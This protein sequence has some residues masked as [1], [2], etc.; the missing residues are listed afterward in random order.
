MRENESREV[1][2]LLDMISL[3]TVPNNF[4]MEQMF[5]H[6]SY[7]S[8]SKKKYKKINQKKTMKQLVA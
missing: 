5:P 4:I 7:R 2:F 1:S 6:D 3:N 8:I